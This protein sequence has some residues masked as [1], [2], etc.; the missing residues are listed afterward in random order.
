MIPYEKHGNLPHPLTLELDLAGVRRRRIGKAG[1]IGLD[2]I[3][4]LSLIDSE[5]GNQPR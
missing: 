2:G 4:G 5:D 3:E 1:T